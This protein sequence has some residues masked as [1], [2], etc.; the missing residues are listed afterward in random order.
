V[1]HILQHLCSASYACPQHHRPV[2]CAAI[3]HIELLLSPFAIVPSSLFRRGVAD[4]DKEGTPRP[5]LFIVPLSIDLETATFEILDTFRDGPMTPDLL[6]VTRSCI[7]YVTETERVLR[8]LEKSFGGSF[9]KCLAR[10]RSSFVAASA[11]HGKQANKLHMEAVLRRSRNSYAEQQR[12]AGRKRREEDAKA[13]GDRAWGATLRHWTRHGWTHPGVIAN[14]ST[15]LPLEYWKVAGED[16]TFGGRERRRLILCHQDGEVVRERRGDGKLESPPSENHPH[17]SASVDNS[18]GAVRTSM[19]E[20]I[21][22]ATDKGEQGGAGCVV[23]QGGDDHAAEEAVEAGVESS[24]GVVGE[25]LPVV[26]GTE[27]L[28]ISLSALPGVDKSSRFL[29]TSRARRLSAPLPANQGEEEEEALMSRFRALTTAVLPASVGACLTSYRSPA[30]T[31][32][33]PP[34]LLHVLSPQL[35]VTT[36]RRRRLKRK[37]RSLSLQSRCRLYFLR[38][39]WQRRWQRWSKR[40]ALWAKEATS[41]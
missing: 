31:P 35:R 9:L 28:S 40:I 25:E 38:P 5:L 33:T 7:E 22:N 32:L 12:V 6:P 19:G 23:E 15:S 36:S 13:R 41:R 26:T 4:Q 8:R 2:V 14:T 39:R 24:K 29:S 10:V 3:T 18:E 1:L 16:S 37:K 27:G 11:Q 34:Y 17:R 21:G 20:E 30:H